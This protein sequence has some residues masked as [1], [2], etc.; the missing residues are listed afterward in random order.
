MI[1]T[2]RLRNNRPEFMYT[3]SECAYYCSGYLYKMFD[4]EN[5]FTSDIDCINHVVNNFDWLNTF[6]QQITF[7]VVD[8]DKDEFDKMQ[9]LLLCGEWAQDRK[10]NFSIDYDYDYDEYIL[11]NV[12]GRKPADSEWICSIFPLQYKELGN[13]PS[14]YSRPTERVCSECGNEFPVEFDGQKECSKVCQ[15]FAEE[16]D[17]TIEI[18][19]QTFFESC[20]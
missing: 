19:Q 16:K 18:E 17:R 8:V 3:N 14:I 13:G 11:I 15:I 7:K 6:H 10:H 20:N 1:K 12:T 9:R 5:I 2:I 4:I